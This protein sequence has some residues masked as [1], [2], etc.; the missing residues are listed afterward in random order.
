MESAQ[1]SVQEKGYTSTFPIL[2]NLN[3]RPT[4]FM[5]L[6]D[7][8]KLT[9]LFA[10]I[11]AQKYQSVAVGSDINEV[12]KNYNKLNSDLIDPSA[13]NN[14][15][16]EITLKEIK[17]INLEGNTIFYFTSEEDNL[18][19]IA[20]VNIAQDLIFAKAGD[21]VKINGYKNEDGTFNVTSVKK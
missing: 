18:I 12:V 8:A 10:L 17:E 3:N 14:L 15:T 2:I 21:K 16:L 11:D 9:K 1:G 5:S 20:P 19:Y 7:E 13:E 4:Y 6:K